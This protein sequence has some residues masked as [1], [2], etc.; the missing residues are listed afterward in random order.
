MGTIHVEGKTFISAKQ[1]SSCLRRRSAICVR[2]FDMAIL[3]LFSFFTGAIKPIGLLPEH[4]DIS[5]HRQ[6]S[7]CA[8]SCLVVG[9]SR[10]KAGTTRGTH[11]INADRERHFWS[12]TRGVSLW[13]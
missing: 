7:T 5:T 2:Y 3:R 9:R 11:A 1:S 8:K 13:F 4:L 6:S 12:Q 10:S